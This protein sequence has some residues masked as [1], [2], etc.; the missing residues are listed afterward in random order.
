MKIKKISCLR[1]N[2]LKVL[3]ELFYARQLSYNLQRQ[4][5]H[6]SKRICF[7][8][9]NNY[10]TL[11]IHKPIYLFFKR[12]QL[13]VQKLY[14]LGQGMRKNSESKFPAFKENECMEAATT[15]IQWPFQSSSKKNF[16]VISDTE[17]KGHC[18][19]CYHTSF[20]LFQHFLFMD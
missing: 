20:F 14:Y 13:T 5:R 4:L 8:S 6:F 18:Y 15:S 12:N 16:T 2:K 19:L 3:K 9:Y 7:P 17:S 11:I 1:T 10:L